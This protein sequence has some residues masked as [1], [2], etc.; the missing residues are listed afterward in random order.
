MEFFFQRQQQASVQWT[1]QRAVQRAREEAEAAQTR[2][3][4]KAKAA[5]VRAEDEANETG[6]ETAVTVTDT[7]DAGAETSTDAPDANDA[8]VAAVM[9]VEPQPI[10]PGVLSSSGPRLNANWLR[11]LLLPVDF[12]LA[13]KTEV[14]VERHGSSG[15]ISFMELCSC[16][17]FAQL[18]QNYG[19]SFD[20]YGCC[21]IYK[22]LR[23]AA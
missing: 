23:G 16:P 9:P 12:G 17:D 2:A 13:A 18:A 14:I 21:D 5:E 6:P 8:P 20:L 15:T 11:R 10:E 3:D 7:V 1:Q 19:A 22:A 4:E